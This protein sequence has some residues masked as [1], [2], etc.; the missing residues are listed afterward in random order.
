MLAL[1]V[2]DSLLAE[3]LQA[4]GG[5]VFIISCLA[6]APCTK[7]SGLQLQGWHLPVPPQTQLVDFL[8]HRAAAGP[9]KTVGGLH[10]AAKTAGCK[11]SASEHG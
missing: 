2:P 4:G 8:L 5:T 7:S 10:A 11:A 6:A 3:L 1:Q 9:C